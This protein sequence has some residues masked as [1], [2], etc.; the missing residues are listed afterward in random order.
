VHSDFL[1]VA[2]NLGVIGGLIFFGGCVYTLLRLG[3]RLLPNLRNRKHGDLGLSLL[4][5]FIAV[6]GILAMEGV[7]VLPQLALPVWFVWA[8]AEVW[9]RQTADVREFNAAVAPR[10]PYPLTPVRLS[11]SFKADV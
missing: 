3:R 1:Q 7:T 9:L 11:T 6:L 8:L 4:L 5:S 10:H 2:V